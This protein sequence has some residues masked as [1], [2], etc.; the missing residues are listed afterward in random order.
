MEG[1][2]GSTSLKAIP[3]QKGG[4]M[5]TC[6]DQNWSRSYHYHSLLTHAT[7]EFEYIDSIPMPQIT[8]LLNHFFWHEAINIHNRISNLP[9]VYW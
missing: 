7:P 3:G 1:K 8:V 2:R 5:E 6:A 4:Q 9:L